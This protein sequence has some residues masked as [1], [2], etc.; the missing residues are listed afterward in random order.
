MTQLLWALQA[1]MWDQIQGVRNTELGVIWRSFLVAAVNSLPLPHP[2]HNTCARPL[3]TH[4]HHI[5][6]CGVV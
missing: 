6:T 1:S 3:F 5:T 2:T 4:N